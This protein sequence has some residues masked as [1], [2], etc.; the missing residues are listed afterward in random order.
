MNHKSSL[1]PYWWLDRVWKRSPR[2]HC[3]NRCI[4]C[5]I[6][7]KVRNHGFS[8]HPR[9]EHSSEFYKAIQYLHRHFQPRNWRQT[10]KSKTRRSGRL[11][12]CCPLADLRNRC[13]YN[14]R[15]KQWWLGSFQLLIFCSSRRSTHRL[16]ISSNPR[17][18]GRIRINLTIWFHRL[19][20]IYQPDI[21]SLHVFF[22]KA[23]CPSVN[24]YTIKQNLLTQ[25]FRGDRWSNSPISLLHSPS[26]K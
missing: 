7:E 5:K 26:S 6:Q 10:Q 16:I 3:E 25:I 1:V 2:S 22:V 24:Y 19:T 9:S 23:S 13:F 20:D 8:G 11:D 4:C 17:I 21:E 12:G 15:R 18:R 14:K